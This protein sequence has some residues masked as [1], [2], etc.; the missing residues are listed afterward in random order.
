MLL[1]AALKIILFTSLDKQNIF[2]IFITVM[3]YYYFWMCD[4][5]ICSLI[6]LW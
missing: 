3:I 1:T 4:L 6:F 5:F 2:V